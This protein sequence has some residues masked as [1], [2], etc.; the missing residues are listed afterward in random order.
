MHS[1]FAY[2]NGALSQKAMPT[3][4]IEAQDRIR[5]I[6]DL[7][8]HAIFCIPTGE[9]L[10]MRTVIV[11]ILGLAALSIGGCDGWPTRFSNQTAV[12][13]SFSYWHN[14]LDQR[15]AT[16]LLNAGE[17]AL[18]AREHRLRDF[19][20]ISVVEGGREVIISEADLSRLK[21]DCPTYQCILT[22]AGGG[23]LSARPW[24]RDDVKQNSSR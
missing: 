17:S 7:S 10:K 18:L 22:Y 21:E 6:A 16:F 1:R 2:Q 8:R 12:P 23:R 11:V 3:F 24:T 9:R 14:S 19:R 15:S 20:E 5:P 13:V 4:G